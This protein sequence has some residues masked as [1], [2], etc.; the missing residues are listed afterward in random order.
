MNYLNFFKIE[1]LIFIK[2]VSWNNFKEFKNNDNL[3]KK[4][5]GKL[6]FNINIF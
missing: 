4:C 1:Y 3:F 2:C 5:I 6:D